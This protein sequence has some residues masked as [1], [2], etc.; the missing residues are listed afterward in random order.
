[1]TVVVEESPP[2]DFIMPGE[3]FL[4]DTQLCVDGEHFA[5]RHG[6]CLPVYCSVVRR[7]CTNVSSHSKMLDGIVYAA[8][9][10]RSVKKGQSDVDYRRLHDEDD[11][12]PPSY[13]DVVEVADARDVFCNV[14]R[15]GCDPNCNAQA[16][17]DDGEGG[18]FLENDRKKS[19]GKSERLM[20][21]PD[22]CSDYYCRVQSR[23]KRLSMFGRVV[24]DSDVRVRSWCDREE[25]TWRSG[26]P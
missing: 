18:T 20:D 26:K 12:L 4:G 23:R 3:G 13:E 22:G 2:I 24:F 14:R 21:E 10:G 1:M 5:G 8:D 15:H 16:T 25:Q 7:R 6:N 11:R 19:V 9:S 17:N